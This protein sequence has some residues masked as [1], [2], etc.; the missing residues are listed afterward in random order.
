MAYGDKF[1]VIGKIFP[2]R[3]ALLGNREGKELRYI[4]EA[5]GESRTDA[6]RRHYGFGTVFPKKGSTDSCRR[7]RF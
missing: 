5:G 3:S 2:G 4:G 6:E 7:L 1:P